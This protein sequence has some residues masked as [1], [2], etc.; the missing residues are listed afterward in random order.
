MM[1]IAAFLLTTLGVGAVKSK[2]AYVSHQADLE[3][4]TAFLLDKYRF[5]VKNTW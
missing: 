4:T 2:D 5:F 1:G 3:L